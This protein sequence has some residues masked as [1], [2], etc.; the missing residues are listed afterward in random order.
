MG[1]KGL[2]TAFSDSVDVEKLC[3]GCERAMGVPVVNNPGGQSLADSGKGH[4]LL[5]ICLIQIQHLGIGGGL[6]L[7]GNGDGIGQ[8]QIPAEEQSDTQ[9]QKEKGKKP[10]CL[11]LAQTGSHA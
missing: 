4:E 6:C 9:A 7:W 5:Q 11:L 2:Q 8:R 3:H 10:L 1:E